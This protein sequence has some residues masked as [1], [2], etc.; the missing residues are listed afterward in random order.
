MKTPDVTP[1]QYGTWIA[2]V[3]AAAVVL[4]K[5]NLSGVDQGILVAGIVSAVGIGQSISDA[6]VRHGRATVAASANN[7]A[8]A[9]V[10]NLPADGVDTAPPASS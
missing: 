8:A 4:F 9:Q 1:N 5:L 6:I 10:A 7:L 3:V 2:G